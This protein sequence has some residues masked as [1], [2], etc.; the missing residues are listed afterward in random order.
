M[1]NFKLYNPLLLYYNTTRIISFIDKYLFDYIR[2]LSD[3]I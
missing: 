1:N 2:F 3:T